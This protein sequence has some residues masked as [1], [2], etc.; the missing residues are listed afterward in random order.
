MATVS[1]SRWFRAT[2]QWFIGVDLASTRDGQ[3]LRAQAL[4]ATA[5]AI[6]F[7]PEWGRNR[8]RGMLANRPDWCLSRQRAWGLPIPA[9]KNLDGE[10]LLTAASV[11]AVAAVFADRGSDAWFTEPPEALLAGYD[12]GADPDAPKSLQVA[13]LT[14]MYDIFDVWFESGSSWHAVM[15]RRDLG[16]PV[17]LYLEGSDQHR[18]WFQLSLLPGVG[19]TGQSPFKAVLTHGF[20]VDKTGRKMSKSVGNTIDVEDLLKQYGAD[21]CRWWVSSLPFEN[22]VKMDI[23]FFDQAGE[24]YRKVRNTLRFLLS[25]L[26]DLQLGGSPGDDGWMDAPPV[27]PTSLDA[28]VLDRAA[29]VQGGVIEAFESYAFRRAHQLLYEFCNETLSAFYCAAAKDRLYCDRADAPRRRA[30]QAHWKVLLFSFMEQEFLLRPLHA[31]DP[32]CHRTTISR[33]ERCSCPR[34][35]LPSTPPTS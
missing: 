6:E 32:F 15:R 21:V 19:V 22:D 12:P 5:E 33:S 25:N 31:A 20:T 16:F 18:G 2:E 14:K 1:I 10:V 7:I 13:Q 8:M 26:S 11:R 34:P 30:T 4:E 9:F 3:S 24:T 23:A 29:A 17:D 28:W 27:D 35:I